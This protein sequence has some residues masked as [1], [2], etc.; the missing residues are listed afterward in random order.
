MYV[1]EFCALDALDHNC[2]R[3]HHVSPNNASLIERIRKTLSFPFV[4]LP[5][6]P[7]PLPFTGG[8]YLLERNL[9]KPPKLLCGGEQMTTQLL[10]TSRDQKGRGD[11]SN[12]NHIKHEA[13]ISFSSFNFPKLMKNNQE[14]SKK[15]TVSTYI[16]LHQIIRFIQMRKT[17]QT[18]SNG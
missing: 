15:I 12:I 11:N 10:W 9:K 18:R 1:N 8:L 4:P 13:T 16:Y 17:T 2:L 3:L 6:P 14:S 5:L 7:L